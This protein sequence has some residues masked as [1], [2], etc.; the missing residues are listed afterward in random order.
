MLPVYKTISVEVLA[1]VNEVELSILREMLQQLVKNLETMIGDKK[2]PIFQ[3]FQRFLMVTHLL[4][5]KGEAARNNLDR[6]SAKLC[7]SLLRYCKDIRADKAFYDA[8]E[9][10][11]KLNQ[12]DAAFIFFNRYIDLYDAIED[13]ENNG[14]SENTDF[15]GTDIPSPYD[16]SLPEKNLLSEAE[17]DQIRDW[18]LQIN[19]DGGISNS[20][21]TRVCEYCQFD[22]LY[23]AALSCQQCKSTWEPCVITGYPLIKSQS[24]SCKFCNMGALR[25]S[26][27]DFIGVTMHCPWCN[28]MQTQY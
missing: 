11:R 22:Q 21:P 23:D 19:M 18:V 3:E 10:N 20:L 26:W 12:N 4:L 14:I 15:E 1:T 6:V 7:T 2:N 17:R 16:I 24:I 25:D 13:P 9:A 27:N 5:L 8:G 28:S